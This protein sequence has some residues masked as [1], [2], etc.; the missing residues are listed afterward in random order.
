M[1]F[2]DHKA[3][4]R[5]V[6]RP[7]MIGKYLAAMD[8]AEADAARALIASPV[9]SNEYVARVFT[10]EGYPVSTN[11]VRTWRLAHGGGIYP[12]PGDAP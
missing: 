5:P 8:A 4:A 9:T 3:T 11:S 2:A 7:S 10:A 1:A 12:P 6:G